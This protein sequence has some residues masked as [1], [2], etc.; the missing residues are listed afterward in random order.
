MTRLKRL[1]N[2]RH[3]LLKLLHQVALFPVD[4]RILEV[5]RLLVV[6]GTIPTKAG[7][8]QCILRQ[9]VLKNVSFF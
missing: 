3:G 7:Q 8:M 6:P 4:Q 9:R 2:L 1:P 5:A